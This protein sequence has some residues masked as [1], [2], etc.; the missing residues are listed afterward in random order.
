L[1]VLSIEEFINNNESLLKHED[2][3]LLGLQKEYCYM[4]EDVDD[5]VLRPY[6]AKYI[7]SPKMQEMEERIA[8]YI[9]VRYYIGGLFR[10]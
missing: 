2:I 4:L 3:I 1:S 5:V 9:E 8:D 10:H 7:L 6:R